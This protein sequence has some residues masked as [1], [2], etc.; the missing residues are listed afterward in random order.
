MMQELR[1][2]LS[3]SS[4]R[5]PPPRELTEWIENRRPFPDHVAYIE[6]RYASEPY[7]LILSL[8]ANDLA[9]ASRDEMKKHLLGQ[10]PHQARLTAQGLL[11]PL[12]LIASALPETL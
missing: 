4:N 11:A 5:I 3:V 10:Y 2:R 8:L 7:R 6:Q 1:R 9:E 12:E